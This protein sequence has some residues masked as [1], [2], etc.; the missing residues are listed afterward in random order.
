M[1]SDAG[2]LRLFVRS[3][4]IDGTVHHCDEFPHLVIR[5]DPRKT[6]EKTILGYNLDEVALQE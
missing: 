6:A 5:Q 4:G 1:R 3:V 2:A